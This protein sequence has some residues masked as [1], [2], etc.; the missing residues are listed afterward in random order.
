[1]Q[2]C[3]IRDLNEVS[4]VA[5][6]HFGEDY[7]LW[8]R[9]RLL[10][11]DHHLFYFDKDLVVYVEPIGTYKYSIH[12]LG[13]TSRVKE[14]RDFTISL[15]S[16]VFANTKCTSLVTFVSVNNKRLQRFIGLTGGQRVGIIPDAGG[17]E[18]EIIYVYPIRNRI[19]LESRR[20]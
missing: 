4:D 9:Q 10:A 2:P 18:D 11:P 8:V 15:G 13:E 17:L 16:W 6:R 3:T 7:T 20:S 12:L 5:S 14:L 1:M 19:E